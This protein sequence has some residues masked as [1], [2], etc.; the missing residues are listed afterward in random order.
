[1]TIQEMKEK[2]RELGYSNAQIAE[3]TGIPLG[4]VQKIF[5]GATV[6]P[7]YETISMLEKLFSPSKSPDSY[8][9][10]SPQSYSFTKKQGEYTLEDYYKIP[11]DQRVELIDGVIYDIS[12]PTSAHQLIAGIAYAQLY[13][14]VSSKKGRCIPFISPIDV[15]LDCDDKTMV[16]PDVIIV[17]DRSKVINRCVYGAPDFVLEVLSPST[18][19]KDMALKMY[20]YQNA[21]VR[22]YW[23]V[24]PDKRK[25]MVYDLEHDSFPTLYGFD[26]K[27]PVAIWNG[28]CEIDFQEIYENIRFLYGE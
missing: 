24:D 17:C 12:A 23:L 10:E 21:G 6:S 1:M 5:S 13:N 8:I 14:H 9:S 22:E 3:L 27:V 16:Q 18:R 26:C 15:Q 25:V 7:R 20:K 28:E 4:T 11:D 2:K 19:K